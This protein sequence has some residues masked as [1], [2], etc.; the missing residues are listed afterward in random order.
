MEQPSVH[1]VSEFSMTIRKVAPLLVSIAIALA[2][3][4]AM[5]GGDDECVAAKEHM[6]SKI[7]D[8]GCSAWLMDTAQQKIVDACGQAE[9]DAYIPAVQNA[10]SAAK[11]SGVAM[12]CGDIAGKT[13]AGPPSDAGGACGGGTSMSFSYAGTATADGRPAQLSFTISGTSVT[14]GTLY[15]TG[16][17]ANNIRLTTTNIA[18]TGVLSGSWESATGMISASW[19]G[20]DSVCGT[21]L[22]AVDGYPQSG[23]LTISLASGKVQLQRIISGAEPYEFSPTGQTYTP[24][25]VNCSAPTADSGVVG[26]SDTKA[27]GDALGPVCTKL[28]ACCPTVTDIPALQSD[29]YKTLENGLGDSGCQITWDSLTRLGYCAGI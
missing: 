26:G 3:S 21:Q 17:C 29:C 14:G 28:A 7:T 5:C 22:T 8:M 25:S 10:C 12:S 11:S 18:F 24:P 23:S 6:C 1:A 16:T 2:T 20:G 4:G 27:A 9:L 15:A 19:T 13:Y